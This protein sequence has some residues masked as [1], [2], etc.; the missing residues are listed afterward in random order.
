MD[1]AITEG[2][3]VVNWRQLMHNKQKHQETLQKMKKIV[4]NDLPFSYKNRLNKSSKEF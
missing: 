4:D 1:R 3:R 2:N